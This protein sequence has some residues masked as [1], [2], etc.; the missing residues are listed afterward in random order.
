MRTDRITRW[1]AVGIADEV[2]QTSVYTATVDTASGTVAN[3][4][5]TG[6]RH[7]RSRRPVAQACKDRRDGSGESE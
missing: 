4:V 6:R 2:A 1:T 5:C 3:T 7:R